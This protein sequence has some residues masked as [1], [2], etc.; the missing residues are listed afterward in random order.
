MGVAVS[1]PRAM[2]EGRPAGGAP[3]KREGEEGTGWQSADADISVGVRDPASLGRAGKSMA[4]YVARTKPRREQ[5]A[6]AVLV[7]R[8]VEVYL[9]VL[10]RRKHRAG[11]RDWEPLFPCYLFASLQV[12]S[13]QWLAARSAPD[14][15]YFL[16]TASGEG[17][18]VALPED[19]VPALMARVDL[20]NR[21]GGLS[22]FKPGDRV[23]IT[24]GPFRYLEAVFDRRLSPSGRARV[25]V[26]LLRRLVPVELPE[27]QLKRAV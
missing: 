22:R 19:F 26:R 21:D 3:G 23:V 1:V 2:A 15:A 27:E 14:V 18:P 17:Y 13:D 6:A 16:G 4:W 9:P 20:A 12:P 5:Q 24:S 7:Q 11:R 25:L 8:G 10:R